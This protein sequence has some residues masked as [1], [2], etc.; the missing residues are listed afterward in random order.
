MLDETL[1]LLNL[2]IHTS[3]RP[4]VPDDWAQI[5]SSLMKQEQSLLPLSD[6]SVSYGRAYEALVYARAASE[7]RD[8]QQVIEALQQAVQFL[9]SGLPAAE[10]EKASAR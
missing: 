6:L 8:A 5:G 1:S 10:T 3:R 4:N 7:R 2:M 9:K